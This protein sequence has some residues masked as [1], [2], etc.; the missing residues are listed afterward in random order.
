MVEGNMFR[1]EFEAYQQIFYST[2][3]SGEW[4]IEVYGQ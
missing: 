4:P 1:K 3:A 2:M